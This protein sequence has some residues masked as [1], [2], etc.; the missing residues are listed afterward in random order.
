MKQISSKALKLY[1]NLF[2]KT[3]YVAM[4]CQTGNWKKLSFV[5]R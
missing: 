3:N 5:V 4:F 1:Q 2:A